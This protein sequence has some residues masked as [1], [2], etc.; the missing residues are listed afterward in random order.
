VKE[1]ETMRLPEIVTRE[2]WLVVRKAHLAKEKELTRAL[3][4]PH[5]DRRRLPMVRIDEDYT[6]E[7]PRCGLSHIFQLRPRRGRHRG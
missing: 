2:E 3:D 6:F 7:G 5:G 1:S 4:A